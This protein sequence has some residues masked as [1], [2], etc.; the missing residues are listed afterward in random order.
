VS[1]ALVGAICA[2]A[3]LVSSGAVLAPGAAGSQTHGSGSPGC[4]ARQITTP[5]DPSNPLALPEA[6]GSDPLH[7]A[8]FFVDGPAHGMV[9]QAIEGLLHIDHNAYSSAV[10]WAQFRQQV[11]AKLATTSAQTAH[12]IT[13]LFKIGEQ[14][15]PQNVSLFNQGGGR[16]AVRA[17]V[18]KILCQNLAA[19]PTPDTVPVFTTFF[20]RPKG[21]ACAS[22]AALS[23]WWPTFRRMVG[24]MAGAIADARAV[25][26]IETDS[27]SGIGC[28]GHGRALTLWLRELHYEAGAFARLRHVVAYLEAGSA[29]EG[30]ARPT[31]KLLV[32]AGV[33]M[34]RGFYT[35][36]NHMNWS[37]AEISR[38]AAI[39]GDVRRL[40]ARRHI[41]YTAHFVV[42]TSAN[43]QGPKTIR[44]GLE[45][46]CNPPGR[47]LG[48]TPTAD[49]APTFDGHLFGLLDAFLWSGVPGRSYGSNCYRGAAPG[50]TFDL[51]YGLELA[52]NANQKLG[53]GSPSSPY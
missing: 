8:H 2:A 9:A 27:L 52:T 51:R 33:A 13:E 24:E 5:R 15:E 6:P 31:A 48:R 44:H 28:F 7:G 46:V 23:A 17:Q 34:I 39:S 1:S 45:D 21:K 38:G 53:P 11:Q 22:A 32:Q 36:D 26:L 19:D 50:G 18:S 47:G 16:G 37:S 29:D 4:A 25:V 40:L 3:V 41:D 20:A 30:A 42:N 49:T 12:E 35:N 10:S 43:G 14:E